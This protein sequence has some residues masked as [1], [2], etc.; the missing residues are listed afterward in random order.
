MILKPKKKLKKVVY[1]EPKPEKKE[2][3]PNTLPPDEY[4]PMIEPIRF[5]VRESDSRS[6]GQPFRQYVELTVKRYDDD[7][8]SPFVWMTMYQESDFYTGY[9]KGKSV[10]FPLKNALSDVIGYLVEL[11]EK[12]YDNHIE[13]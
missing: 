1:E 12:C 11:E 5:L 2:K 6:T 3:K 10:H 9:L 7:E 13:D 4:E 8:A